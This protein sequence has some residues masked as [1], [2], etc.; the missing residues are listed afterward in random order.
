MVVGKALR[1]FRAGLEH[2]G[3][4]GDQGQTITPPPVPHKA[5]VHV[6]MT[7]PYSSV[8]SWL[9]VCVFVL[10]SELACDLDAIGVHSLIDV[11][12][13]HTM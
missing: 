1:R 5:N 13:F 7:T 2:P 3:P 10:R 6:I 12:R 11:L 8:S 4:A 9:R